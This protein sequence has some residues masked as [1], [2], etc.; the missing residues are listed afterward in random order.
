VGQ[1]YAEWIPHSDSKIR[2]VEYYIEYPVDASDTYYKEFKALSNFPDSPKGPIKSLVYNYKVNCQNL[3]IQTK[4]LE[5]FY[6]PMATGNK[7]G[8]IIPANNEHQ[9]RQIKFLPII[10]ANNEHQWRQIKFLKQERLARE[11]CKKNNTLDIPKNR[12]EKILKTG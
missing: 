12:L 6:G 1:V 4:G 11:I 10:P 5:L 7:V 3:R 9:W 2:D 8:P